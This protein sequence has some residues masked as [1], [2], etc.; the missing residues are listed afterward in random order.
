VP[1]AAPAG[2]L[3]PN[4]LATTVEEITERFGQDV[5]DDPARVRNLLRDAYGADATRERSDIDTFVSVLDQ[6]PLGELRRGRSQDDLARAIANSTTIDAATAGWTLTIIVH[7]TGSSGGDDRTVV[8]PID[9]VQLGN[10]PNTPTNVSPIATAARSGGGGSRRTTVLVLSAALVAI[11]IAGIAWF[12]GRSGADD[13][14]QRAERAEAELASTRVES[15]DPGG[16]DQGDDEDDEDDADDDGGADDAG[17]ASAPVVPADVTELESANAELAE[18]NTALTDQLAAAQS[19]RDAAVADLQS[20]QAELAA[21]QGKLA[22]FPAPLPSLP[23][24]EMPVTGEL[25]S[26]EGFNAEG[27]SPTFFLDAHTV[28]DGGQ[29]LLEARGVALIPLASADGLTWS[30]VSDVIGG[31]YHTC[32]DQPMQ[33][34]M[35][36]ELK[37]TGLVA[38][39]ANG[40]IAADG[41]SVRF[42]ITNAGGSCTGATRVY[43]GYTDV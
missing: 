41:Y 1:A 3:N 27:C 35:V 26:C 19:E 40:A 32:G 37:P 2:Y 13:W 18:T 25:V 11:A 29:Y 34:T 42:T 24:A 8:D 14:K 31:G 43:F 36:V 39:P 16:L 33:T 7:A 28:H 17:V 22:A 38:N 4:R 9:G 15:A 30:G 5:L 21:A 23:I 12:A 10:R 6:H 20:T